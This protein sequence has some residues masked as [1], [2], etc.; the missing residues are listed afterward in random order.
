MEGER[1]NALHRVL[2][3]GRGVNVGDGRGNDGE[4]KGLERLLELGL[5]GLRQ[6]GFA[7]EDIVQGHFRCERPNDI[8]DESCHLLARVGEI[9]VE[10]FSGARISH[11][12]LDAAFD[13]QKNIVQCLRLAAHGQRLQA[14]ADRAGLVLADA[15][16][17]NTQA[18]APHRMEAAELLDDVDRAGLGRA[19]KHHSGGRVLDERNKSRGG[20]RAEKGFS[21]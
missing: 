15:R 17:Q 4:A 5:D 18:W 20:L 10:L 3:T 13:V 8:K 12:V 7:R 6:L 14:Q 11:F 16:D 2:D 21:T 19:E 1:Q 9:V